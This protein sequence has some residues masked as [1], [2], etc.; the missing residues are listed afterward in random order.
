M[1][2][3]DASS[4]P[5]PATPL[6]RG[7]DQ[8]SGA[9]G[10]SA[11]PCRRDLRLLWAANAVDG[12]GSQASGV[13]FPLLLLSMGHGPGAAGAFASAAAF[14]GVA[15]G[16]LVAVPADRGHRRRIMLGTAVLSATAMA[17]L[18]AASFAG[19]APLWLL[20]ALALAERL[21]ATAYEAASRGA[22]VH[23]AD[24]DELPSA[25]AGLQAGDQ[26]ALVV[27]PAFG[28]ALFQL[29][30]PLPFLADA[31]SYVATA[32][33]V[34]S[35][36]TPIES[37]SHGRVRPRGGRRTA[38][39]LS[40]ALGA[41]AALVAGSPV[42]RF[43]VVWTSAVSGVV[44]LLSYTAL[45]V[46]GAHGATAATGLVL[47]V[48]G[49][50][51]LLGSLLSVRIVRRLGSLRTLVAATWLLL[52]PL[53]ALVAADGP[54]TYG[55]GLAVLCLLLPAVTVVLS[56][57]A[58]A[59]VPH[60]LQSRAGAVVGASAALA[61][62]GAPALAGALV[63]TAGPW[64]PAAV[65]TG[66]VAV[67]AVYTHAT[68]PRTLGTTTAEGTPEDRTAGPGGHAGAGTEGQP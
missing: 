31:V 27:G 3:V 47:S 56:S 48:S 21:C 63:T 54:W 28:G 58:V 67:L 36:R 42:L 14:A 32:V 20:G 18:A 35:I 26:V 64:A 29:A 2:T 51:G 23:L 15:I 43:V 49:A 55:P 7:G 19:R 62:A 50:T 68:A 57:T 24:H 22:L 8:P 61:A 46:L 38:R 30:R 52:V 1:E 4:A 34:R 60:T 37:P 39:A 12:L 41:G 11:R 59:A 6:G 17:G 25:A 44:T 13:V 65:C 16:P 40:G 9:T 45:F 33:G 10:P 53:G 66:A 5:Q